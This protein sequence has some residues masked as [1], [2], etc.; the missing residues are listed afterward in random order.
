M[1]QA[2]ALGLGAMFKPIVKKMIPPNIVNDTIDAAFGVVGLDKPINPNMETPQ[3]FVST[4]YLNFARGVEH[5]DKMAVFPEVIAETTAETFAT[6]NDE[7]SFSDLKKRFTYLGSFNQTTSQLPGS[8]LATFPLNPC[9]DYIMTD[10][11]KKVPLLTY[12]SIPFTFWRGGLTYKIQVVSTSFQTSKIFF[13]INYGQYSGSSSLPIADATSQYGAAF[14]INQGSNEFEFTVPYVSKTHSLFV[15]N[16]N[17]P[18]AQDSLGTINVAVLNTLVA[19]NN[20]P[21]TISY[22]VFIAG[23]DDFQLS[24][25]SAMNNIL[26]YFPTIL[27]FEVEPEFEAHSAVAPLNSSETD[28]YK[29]TSASQVL[30]P[31][32]AVSPRVDL[33]EHDFDNIRNYLKKYQLW[34]RDA[35]QYIQTGGLPQNYFQNPVPYRVIK[36]SDLIRPS[37]MNY[38][39]GNTVLYKLTGGLFTHYS[40]MYRLFKGSVRVKIVLDGTYPTLSFAVYYIPP[41]LLPPFENY[42]KQDDAVASTMFIPG[43][44]GLGG[45]IPSVIPAGFIPNTCRT[46]LPVTV[47]NGLQKTVDFELPFNSIYKS[48][49]NALPGEPISS[50]EQERSM[51]LGAILILPYPVDAT[52]ERE[53]NEFAFTYSI[54]TALNDESRYGVLYNVPR[55]YPSVVNL[56]LAAPP[57]GVISTWPDYFEPPDTSNNT[58]VKLL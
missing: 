41:I 1:L 31:E 28:T 50:F 40:S 53:S 24:T 19:P 2:A 17:N 5:I 32:T 48:V 58:L 37:Q 9:P 20:T 42:Y 21:L 45:A 56:S 43:G 26:P 14:E 38:S 3:R 13:S 33:V 8:I 25:L 10:G 23:A 46:R 57:R 30:S 52:S 36:V 27:P 29:E 7:M 18:T 35:I 49:F 22:N 39:T 55:I 11:F 54:Y 44:M 15:P 16:N 47:C 51:D 4:S 34:T 12:L 6:V